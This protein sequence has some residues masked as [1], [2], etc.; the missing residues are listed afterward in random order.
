MKRAGTVAVLLL[1]L[2]VGAQAQK[3]DMGRSVT[4]PAGSK[5]FVPSVPARV[6]SFSP[7][8]NT[9]CTNSALIPAALGCT[10]PYFTPTINFSTGTVEFGRTFRLHPGRHHR[11]FGFPAYA[12]YAVYPAY[13]G[14]SYDSGQAAAVEPEEED[15]PAPTIFEHR[16]RSER[17]PAEVSRED[18]SRYGTHYLDSRERRGRQAEAE[19]ALMEESPTRSARDVNPVV[20][21]FRDGHEEEVSNYAIMGGTLYDLGTFVA[22]KIKLADLNLKATVKA[23]NDRGL[24]FSLPAAYKVN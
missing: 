6:H 24:D 23:N 17:L 14:V 4:A 9:T 12:P 18:S 11:G 2:A 5:S 21:I 10:D 8:F 20:L 1:A 15:P 16:A 19:P 13:P 22:H 7:S 3:R